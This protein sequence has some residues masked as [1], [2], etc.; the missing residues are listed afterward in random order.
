[1]RLLTATAGH[2]RTHFI[3]RLSAVDIVADLKTKGHLLVAI[4]DDCLQTACGRSRR[5]IR[6]HVLYHH[7]NRKRHAN[8]ST[9]WTEKCP[10]SPCRHSSGQPLLPTEPPHWPPRVTYLCHSAA[11]KKVPMQQK[12]ESVSHQ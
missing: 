5:S 9:E 10:P 3:F 2:I 4:V 11:I 1:M 12:N 8:K 6:T 7:Y